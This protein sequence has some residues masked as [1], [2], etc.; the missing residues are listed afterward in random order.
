MEKTDKFDF[1]E[2]MNIG[3]N[4]P[5][6]AGNLLSHETAHS[7]VK[8]GLAMTYEGEYVLTE[9]G[10]KLYRNILAARKIAA[11]SALNK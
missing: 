4:M 2:L 11:Q 1:E 10:K 9:E 5:V 3:D 6:F 7:L 8:K